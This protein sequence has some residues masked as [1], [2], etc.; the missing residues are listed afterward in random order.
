[1]D[2]AK[3]YEFARQLRCI[4]DPVRKQAYI[5]TILHFLRYEHR[6]DSYIRSVLRRCG[7]NE[8]E[9]HTAFRLS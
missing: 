4:S 6:E 1:M 2:A 3:R 9:I 8:H 7:L 5:H